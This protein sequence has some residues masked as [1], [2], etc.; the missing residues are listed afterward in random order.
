MEEQGRPG[1]PPTNAAGRGRAVLVLLGVGGLLLVVAAVLTGLL[2]GVFAT[3][4]RSR[5]P[6]DVDPADPA[7]PTAAHRGAQ[8]E[9]VLARAPMLDL[10]P[11]AA[12]P[13]PLTTR[14][15]GPPI[16]LPEPT[17]VAGTEVPT[18]FP[19]TPEG[20]LAQLAELMTAGMAGGDP[21]TFARAYDS[22][23]EVGAAPVAQTWTSRDLVD[24]RRGSNMATTGPLRAGMRISWTPTS[25][26]VKG[27]SRDGSYVVACVLGEFVADSGGRIVNAGWGNCL[28]MRRVGDQW[29]VASGPTAALAPSAWPGSAAAVAAGW[30]EIRR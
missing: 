17:Q 19:P 23:A 6:V 29:R 11:S 30:R 26:M 28:P 13:H 2:T 20:A 7:G 5:T 18:G 3:G 22:L 24:L 8:A 14:T 10:P 15:A 25:A 16:T 9:A 21:Q 27:T 4:G 1:V 12:A